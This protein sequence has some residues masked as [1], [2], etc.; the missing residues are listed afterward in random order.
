MIPLLTF[1]TIIIL[2][3]ELGIISRQYLL[4]AGSSGSWKPEDHNIPIIDGFSEH[5]GTSREMYEK[6]VK[7]NKLRR[8]QCPFRHYRTVRLVPERIIR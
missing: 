5:S 6:W 8:G 1:S 4:C 2:V 7:L 3:M